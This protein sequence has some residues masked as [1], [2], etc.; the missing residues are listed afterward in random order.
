MLSSTTT[1]ALLA[2]VLPQAALAHY[3]FERLIVN[4]EA[5]EPYEYVRSTTNA[6]SPIEDVTSPS[7]ICNQGGNDAAIRARTKTYEVAAGSEVGFDINS[8]LGHPGP[9]YVYMSRAPDGVALSDYQGDGDWFKVYAL[10]TSHIETNT[11]LHWATF[12]GGQGGAQNFTFT[13]PEDLPTGNYLMRG[14][15]IGLH[16]AGNVGG[17]Q[18]YM[19]CAQLAVTGGGSGTPGPTVNFPGAYAEDDPGVLIGIYWPPP[20]EYISPGPPV[21]P[22]ECEDHTLNSWGQDSDGDCNPMAQ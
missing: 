7:M 22:G 4:G 11:G 20:Q 6:N 2:S 12:P 19:G 15:H 8:E 13:L 16:G 21:W 18:F 10:T 17:A 3:N 5:T 1:L 14:E 9:L